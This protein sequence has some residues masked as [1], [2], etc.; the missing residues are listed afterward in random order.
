MITKI[1]NAL[2]IVFCPTCIAQGRGKL[3]DIK[4]LFS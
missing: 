3:I 1:N 4:G 2:L